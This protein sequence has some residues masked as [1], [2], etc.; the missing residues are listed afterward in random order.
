VA[1]RLPPFRFEA[2]DPSRELEEGA[3]LIPRGFWGKLNKFGEVAGI[4][5]LWGIAWLLRLFRRGERSYGFRSFASVFHDWQR[6]P[7]LAWQTPP[8]IDIELIE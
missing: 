6:S 5:V 3:R 2:A 4:P 1:E 8:D 7:E